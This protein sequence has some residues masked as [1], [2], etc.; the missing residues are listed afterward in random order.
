VTVD[1][2]MVKGELQLGCDVPC[3]DDGQERGLT[4]MYHAVVKDK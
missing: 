4:P 1:G 2:I 3:G